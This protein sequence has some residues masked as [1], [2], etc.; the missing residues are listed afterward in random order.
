MSPISIVD[1]KLVG[2]EEIDAQHRTWIQIYNRLEDAVLTGEESVENGFH[3]RILKEILDFTRIHFATE[4]DLMDDYDYP[5]ASRHRRLH[6]DFNQE[7]YES[8]RQAMGGEPLLNSEL[9]KLVRNWFL[10]H[11]SSEDVRAFQYINE[12]IGGRGGG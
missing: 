9:M 4:E 11:T 10:T 7:I 8:Y 12:E 6:K 1:L 5:D 2:F 3:V